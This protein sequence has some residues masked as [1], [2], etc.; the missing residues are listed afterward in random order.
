MPGRGLGGGPPCNARHPATRPG[1]SAEADWA[2]RQLP[3]VSREFSYLMD[4]PYIYDL[5]ERPPWRHGVVYAIQWAMI[6]FPVLITSAAL[7]A[8]VLHLGPAEQVRFFQLILLTTGVFTTVQCLWGH[9]YPLVDGPAMALLLSFLVL[10]PHGLPA[11]QGGMALGGLLTVCLVLAAKPR[12]IIPFMTPNV[13]GVILMLIALTLLPYLRT[14]MTGADSISPEGSVLQFLASVLLVLLMAGLAHWLR[15]FL[16]TVSLLLGMLAGTGLFFALEVPEVK[17][18][19]AAPWLSIPESIVPSRP[20]FTLSA[21]VAFAVSYAAVIVNSVGS[22]QGIARITST[23]RLPRALER[24]LLLN[25]IAGVFCG[26]MGT[27]GL[28][29]YSVSPGVVLSNRVASRYAVAYCGILFVLAALSPK[30]AALF[31]IV[32]APVVGAALCAAMG[33][34]IGAALSIISEGGIERRDYYV[35]GVP[36]LV[37]TLLGMLPQEM[38]EG[39]PQ[40]FRVFLGNGLTFGIF[41]VLLLEHGVMRKKRPPGPKKEIAGE[42]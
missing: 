13:V 39:V 32:P 31:A 34:Q 9:R 23:D 8:R 7:P 3:Y 29:S 22:I 36:V 1:K 14:L 42:R 10:A 41:L 5:D 11:I 24:G 25:G 21:V 35:V 28:V 26:L 33:V 12:R 20:G 4:R 2:G 37:G 16:K 6:L 30:L 17:S 18:L 40:V 15:G 27:I 19:L 38:I